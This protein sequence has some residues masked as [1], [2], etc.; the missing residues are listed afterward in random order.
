MTTDNRD[1]DA[2]HSYHEA[3]IAAMK[4]RIAELEAKIKELERKGGKP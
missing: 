1:A 3:R 4:A 2:M